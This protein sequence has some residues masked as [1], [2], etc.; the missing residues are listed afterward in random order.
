MTKNIVRYKGGGGEGRTF[1]S[2][3][4][5]SFSLQ[6]DKERGKGAKEK[7]PTLMVLILNVK[8]STERRK[9]ICPEIDFFTRR[10]I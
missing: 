4:H 8:K 5:S 9:K 10:N 2:H 7:N 1:F 3:S 6:G